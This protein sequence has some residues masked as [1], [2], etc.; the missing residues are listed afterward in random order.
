MATLTAY[1]PLCNQ[2]LGLG[3]NFNLLNIEPVTVSV[4]VVPGRQ[5]SNCCRTTSHQLKRLANAKFV[6]TARAL[7]LAMENSAA[8]GSMV[9]MGELAQSL[10]QRFNEAGNSDR[11]FSAI[12]E[13]LQKN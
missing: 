3:A 9:P 11:D 8:S 10:Y 13:L 5:L 1:T 4:E 12:I 7:G 2:R 6:V